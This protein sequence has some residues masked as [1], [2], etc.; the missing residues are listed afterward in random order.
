MDECYN[1]CKFILYT[2][3][4]LKFIRKETMNSCI[5]PLLRIS[6]M[7]F[8]ESMKG[9]VGPHSI[10]HFMKTT[11]YVLGNYHGRRFDVHHRR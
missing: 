1:N 5:H 3:H 7:H 2:D 8:H 4:A 6:M 11:N 9:F 10:A